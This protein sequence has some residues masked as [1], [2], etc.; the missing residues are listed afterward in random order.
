MKA[1]EVKEARLDNGL[2]IIGEYLPC[3]QSAALGFFVRS[4]AR[5][6]QP[7]ESGVSHF[8]EHMM[9]KGTGS[10]SAIDV[11]CA[12]GQF[13]AQA[14]AYTSEENTV[15]YSAIIPEY[16]SALQELLSDMLRP[17][18]DPQE[19]STEKQVILEEIA[20]YLDRPQFYLYERA[21]NEYFGNHPAGNSVLGTVESIRALS[22]EQMRDYFQRR[23]VPSN[24]VLVAAGNFEWDRFLALAQQY[25]GCWQDMS[26]D[27][28]VDRHSPVEISRQYNKSNLKQGQLLFVANGCSA[29]DQ[30]RYPLTVLATILGDSNGSKLYWE[31][32]DSGLAEAAGADSDERDGTG[33]FLAYASAA[34]DKLEIVKEKVLKIITNPKDF[35]IAELEQAKTKLLTKIVLGGELPMGRLI[36]LGTSWLYEKRINSLADTMSKIK[37]VTRESIEAALELYPLQ[38]WS[39]FSLIPQQTE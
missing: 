11:N 15:F 10:R 2:K 22:C 19:F 25:C 35:S 33:V 14:N 7:A 31:L 27:R 4:G 29:Q 37:A 18:L 21:L 1:V 12:L 30:H 16:F 9:F 28:V 38:Q 8:L 32:V 36:A 23:Y 13:G 17:A 20:L 26:V 39:H 34:P 24:I 6:E 5:D 3:S